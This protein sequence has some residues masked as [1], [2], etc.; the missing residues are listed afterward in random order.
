VG[1]ASGVADNVSV[2]SDAATVRNREVNLRWPA[3]EI[4]FSAVS[5]V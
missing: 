4:K 3:I 5:Y 2:P 1:F